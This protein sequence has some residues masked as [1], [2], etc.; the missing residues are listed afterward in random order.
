M[1]RTP[2]AITEHARIA[3]R[4]PKPFPAE[5]FNIWNDAQFNNPNMTASDAS[6]GIIS[7]AAN[8]RNIQLGLKLE[9]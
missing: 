1:T 7:S 5:A 8:G 3:T 4:A 6:Y 2:A 9:Y